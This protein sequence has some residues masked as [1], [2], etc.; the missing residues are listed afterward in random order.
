MLDVVDQCQEVSRL[1]QRQ[2]D[3]ETSDSEALAEEIRQS[4]TDLETYCRVARQYKVE[5]STLQG[6]LHRN[7]PQHLL[8]AH[9]A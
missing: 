2:A 9:A 5:E 1:C 6:I 8:P 4:L 3:E 7:L